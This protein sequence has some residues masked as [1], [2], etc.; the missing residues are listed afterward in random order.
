MGGTVVCT[1]TGR[2]FQNASVVEV[3]CALPTDIDNGGYEYKGGCLYPCSRVLPN[4]AAALGLPNGASVDDALAKMETNVQVEETLVKTKQAGAFWETCGTVPSNDGNYENLLLLSCGDSVYAFTRNGTSNSPRVSYDNGKTWLIAGNSPHGMQGVYGAAT[5]GEVG[6]VTAGG[7]SGMCYRLTLD[8]KDITYDS[9]YTYLPETVTWWQAAYGN[10]AWVIFP[11][12]GNYAAYAVEAGRD[13]TFS[14]ITLPING[15]LWTCVRFVGDKFIALSTSG[16]IYSYDGETWYS[17]TG[18]SFTNPYSVA[19]KN[20]VYVIGTA[21]SDFGVSDNGIDWRKATTTTESGQGRY[22]AATDEVFVAISNGNGKTY[23]SFDGDTWECNTNAVLSSGNWLPGPES[24]ISHNGVLLAA[25]PYG[26]G[27]TCMT[28]YDEYNYQYELMFP[29]GELNTEKVM[30]ALGLPG[31]QIETGS[32]TGTGTYGSS[33]PNSL[34]FGFEPKMVIIST[35]SNGEINSNHGA[36]FGIWAKTGSNPSLMLVFDASN[37]KGNKTGSASS[38]S[39]NAATLNGNTLSWYYTDSQRQL[40]NNGQ[41][42]MPYHYL[43]IG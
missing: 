24:F 35:S 30:S 43:A 22:V 18:S 4:T 38:W 25:V 16:C 5:N 20:G 28:T 12:N 31:A 27:A 19:Y 17:C 26:N 32:Y 6:Y 8:G 23:Y 13:T 9:V 10:G 41:Y 37:Y 39:W 33:N 42:Y 40:N 15:T 36:T 34:T 29:N 1:K 2:T 3:D 21:D 14:K 7:Q 11:Y